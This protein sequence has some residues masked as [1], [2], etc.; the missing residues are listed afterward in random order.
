MN[1]NLENA[2]PEGFFSTKIDIYQNTL[3]KYYQG[4]KNS[5]IMFGLENRDETVIFMS[6]HFDQNMTIL[7]S[8]FLRFGALNDFFTGDCFVIRINKITY[9]KQKWDVLFNSVF[10]IFPIH[11][12]RVGYKWRMD[13]IT[14]QQVNYE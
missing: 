2:F 10:S 14:Y 3:K 5:Q 8:H 11:L 1:T 6:R 9:S 4:K 12:Y 7:I 13:K